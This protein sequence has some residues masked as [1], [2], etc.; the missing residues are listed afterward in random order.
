MQSVTSYYKPPTTVYPSPGHLAI[1]TTTQKSIYKN[2]YPEASIYPSLSGMNAEKNK[3]QFGNSFKYDLETYTTPT[4]KIVNQEEI[5]PSNQLP[6][7]NNN[8]I[9]KNKNTFNGSGKLELSKD[10]HS[11]KRQKLKNKQIRAKRRRNRF[12]RNLFKNRKRLF[13]AITN[14]LK[15]KRRKALLEDK[16]RRGIPYPHLPASK[17]LPDRMK[18][19]LLVLMPEGP[20]S[21][22]LETIGN[23][24]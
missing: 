2:Y 16:I 11:K 23:A 3:H 20:R 10:I 15:K 8:L 4:T 21:P 5:W 17:Q 1:Q 24:I 14:Y 18:N 9:L 13:P 22:F 7:P 12:F 6:P 19:S